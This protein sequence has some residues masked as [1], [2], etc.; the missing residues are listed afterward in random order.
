MNGRIGTQ[1]TAAV[2]VAVVVVMF[3]T[4][5]AETVAQPC[6]SVTVTST[7]PCGAIVNF[8]TTPPNSPPPFFVA[9]GGS[10]VVPIPPGASV[11]GIISLGGNSYALAGPPFAPGAP[12]G[13]TQ[14]V[15]HV[16]LGPAPGCC[17]DVYF[18]FAPT[19]NVWL[20]PSSPLFPPPCKP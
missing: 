7:S 20:Y 3:L 18:Q 11:Q 4:G 15:P 14:W 13:A 6:A 16:T 10:V 9:A 8:W 2:S 12:A 5:L 17:F 1:R 19:C